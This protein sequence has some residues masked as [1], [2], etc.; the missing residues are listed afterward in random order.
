MPRDAACASNS[1]R[2]CASDSFNTPGSGRWVVERICGTI[3]SSLF[4][5][6][7]SGFSPVSAAPM[8]PT[9]SA[10]AALIGGIAGSA[11][12]APGVGITNVRCDSSAANGSLSGSFGF[13]G[14]MAGTSGTSTDPFRHRPLL[15]EHPKI[16]FQPGEIAGDVHRQAS[17]LLELT[18]QVALAFELEIE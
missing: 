10:P 4:A 14:L 3:A 15:A 2:P 16:E 8:S 5:S 1:R 12:R 7:T 17:A 18:P 9:T 13:A 11:V 6:A